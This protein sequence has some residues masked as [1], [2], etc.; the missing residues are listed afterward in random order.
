VL[1]LLQDAQPQVRGSLRV[2]QMRHHIP[3]LYGESLYVLLTGH[4]PTVAAASSRHEKGCRN[5]PRRVR[6]PLQP[7]LQEIQPRASRRLRH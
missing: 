3:R 1:E 4:E 7:S 5:S 2:L 6:L